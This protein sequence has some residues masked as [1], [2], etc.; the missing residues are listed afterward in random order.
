MKEQKGK[1]K[2]KKKEFRHIVERFRQMQQHEEVAQEKEFKRRRDGREKRKITIQIDRRLVHYKRIYVLSTLAFLSGTIM[3]FGSVVKGLGEG[4][5]LWT[6]RSIFIICGPITIG[7][8]AL[9]LLVA[10]GLV[11][12]RQTKIK[13]RMNMRVFDLGSSYNSNSFQGGKRGS[14]QIDS[15]SKPLLSRETSSSG[16]ST[17]DTS[18]NA[19]NREKYSYNRSS[20]GRQTSEN[21]EMDVYL[22]SSLS[23]GESAGLSFSAKW[24]ALAKFPEQRNTNQ[25]KQNRELTK[26]A[27][28]FA[29]T[30]ECGMLP[31]VVVSPPAHCVVID[32]TRQSN[33]GDVDS[34]NVL[35]RTGKQT[36]I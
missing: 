24:A 21:S 14:C 10:T 34:K 3:T 8:G 36:S 25:V 32:E 7:V 28:T 33:D 29:F 12:E 35:I 17:T 18:G 9:L 13:K 30:S 4:S 20:I 26:K 23:S 11:Y 5:V 6:Y 27:D 22:D 2:K 19:C 1:N 31:A 15:S 16:S